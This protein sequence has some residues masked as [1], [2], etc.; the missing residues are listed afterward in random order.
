MWGKLIKYD[1][2]TL[3]TFLRATTTHFGQVIPFSAFLISHKDPDVFHLQFVV[4]RFLICR[5]ELAIWLRAEE[6]RNELL[7]FRRGFCW[8]CEEVVANWSF[9]SGSCFLYRWLAMEDLTVYMQFRVFRRLLVRLH[10]CD[11]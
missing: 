1:K 8:W 2:R 10:I 9:C 7:R 4:F 11:L 6:A 5:L 3:K